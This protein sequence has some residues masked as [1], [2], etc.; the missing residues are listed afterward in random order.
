MT[1]P[2]NK[3]RM[4]QLWILVLVGLLSCGSPPSAEH[5]HAKAISDH[6]HGVPVVPLNGEMKWKADD[7]TKKNV[8]ALRRVVNDDRYKDEKMRAQLVRMIEGEIDN[9]VKECTMKGPD[10][11]A[12]HVWLERVLQDVKA[13][14]EQK[15]GYAEAYAALQRDVDGFDDAFE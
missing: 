7:A 8:A 9:L 5:D 12:L 15:H 2:R 10:H 6:Q 4:K 14:K 11:D 3:N 1:D 13:L